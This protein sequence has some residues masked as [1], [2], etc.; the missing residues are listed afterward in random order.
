MTRAIADLGGTSRQSLATARAALDAALKG[1]NESEAAK[2]AAELFTALAALDASAP[3]RRAL[4]DASRDAKDKVKLVNDLFAKGA[5]STLALLGE[6]A[7][8]KWS[9]PSDLANAVEQ[10]AIEAEA[11]SANISG[12]LDRLEEEL[13][14][15][16]RVVATENELLQSLSSNK[17]SAEGKRVLVAKLFGGKVSPATSRMLGHLVSGLRGRNLEGTIAFYIKATAAR[18]ARMI[19]NVKSAIALT[20]SQ[21]EKLAAN[22]DSICR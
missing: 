13:F 8:L 4:T 15:F 14:G 5:G 6:L 9:R 12:E 18:R 11:T 1:K 19:A 2:F 16:S 3:L 21:K 10:L 20:D 22:F 7:S 17:Y